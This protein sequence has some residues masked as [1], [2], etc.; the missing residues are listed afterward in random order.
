[1]NDLSFQNMKN[2]NN[3]SV[4]TTKTVASDYLKS[5][6][7]QI[8]EFGE[9]TTLPQA[10]L[11]GFEQIIDAQPNEDD[12]SRMKDFHSPTSLGFWKFR[13]TLADGSEIIALQHAW[14]RCKTQLV[15]P[16]GNQLVFYAA[17]IKET[18]SVTWFD[19]K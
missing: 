2:E 14:D 19:A 11:E 7:K 8:A 3:I 4:T 16:D 5:K 18:A 9:F 15:Q 1:M 12:R 17:G 10:L 6:S 13:V